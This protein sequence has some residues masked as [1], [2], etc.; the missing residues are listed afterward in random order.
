MDCR[1]TFFRNEGRLFL[2]PIGYAEDLI[3]SGAR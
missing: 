3:P 1:L 2:Y